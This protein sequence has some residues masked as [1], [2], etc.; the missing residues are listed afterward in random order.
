MHYAE[1]AEDEVCMAFCRFILSSFG[2]GQVHLA[3]R[4]DIDQSQ[5]LL[6]AIKEYEA[7]KWKEIGKKV[8]KPAKVFSATELSMNRHNPNINRPAS[9]TRKST[10]A[11]N[12]EHIP[13]LSICW[14]DPTHHKQQFLGGILIRSDHRAQGMA[15]A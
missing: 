7:N 3:R 10:L 14:H 12:H 8:G 1:F 9:N 2:A 4:S 11:T 13:V 15:G 5:S 6:L